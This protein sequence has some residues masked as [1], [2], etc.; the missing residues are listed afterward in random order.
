MI[1]LSGKIGAGTAPSNGAIL[2]DF[3]E[4][5]QH[6]CTQK[7]NIFNALFLVHRRFKFCLKCPKHQGRTFDTFFNMENPGFKN[8]HEN[9]NF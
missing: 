8:H 3:S 4:Q 7:S 1:L 5:H 9:L 2:N 6:Q